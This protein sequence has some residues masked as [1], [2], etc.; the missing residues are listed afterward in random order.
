MTAK[1]PKPSRTSREEIER[2]QG[3]I[4]LALEKLFAL[5]VPREPGP[6]LRLVSPIGELADELIA[7][8]STSR[9]LRAYLASRG[10]DLWELGGE[11]E[12][13]NTMRR[14]MEARPE[15]QRWNR[16]MLSAL[17]DDVGLH[18]REIA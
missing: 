18:E 6:S 10:E 7:S 16:A 1:P 8:Q 4:L 5:E 2:Q 12:L 15:R 9:G 14:V 17:W 13:F 3:F 11:L